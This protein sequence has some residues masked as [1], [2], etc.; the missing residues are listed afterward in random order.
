MTI[1]DK[2]RGF[3][4][5]VMKNPEDLEE[6]INQGPHILEGKKVPNHLLI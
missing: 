2:S 1:I 4:F 5:I 3:G 6:I